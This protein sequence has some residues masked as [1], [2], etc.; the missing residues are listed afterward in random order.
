MICP[1]GKRNRY[2]CWHCVFANIYS[3]NKVTCGHPE[4]R[5]MSKVFSEAFQRVGSTAEEAGAAMKE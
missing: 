2:A 4:Y 5:S 3:A 1:M